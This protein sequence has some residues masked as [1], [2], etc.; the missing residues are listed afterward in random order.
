[1]VSHVRT[2][3]EVLDAKEIEKYKTYTWPVRRLSVFFIIVT[4]F[5]EIVLVQLADETGK[6]AMFEVFG[7]Y[8]FG[9]LLVLL[10]VSIYVAARMLH[11]DILLGPRNCRRRCPIVLRF[12]RSGSPAS[13]IAIST[14]PSTLAGDRVDLLVQ[15]AHKVA[16]V[17][18]PASAAL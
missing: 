9:E 7:K 11:R 17:V 4:D 16:R 18:R 10:T 1:M 12:R 6:V 5:V 14:S 13:C 3:V 15:L 2:L 8:V